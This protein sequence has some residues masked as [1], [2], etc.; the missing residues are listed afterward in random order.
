MTQAHSLQF[1]T[2]Y[3]ATQQ[4]GN[5]EKCALL[6]ILHFIKCPLPIDK[7]IQKPIQACKDRAR[8]AHLE[9]QT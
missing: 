8:F 7:A 4:S 3:K 5:T 9:L 1:Y 6:Y 2:T